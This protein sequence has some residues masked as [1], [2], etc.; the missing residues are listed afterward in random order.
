M[1]AK[2]LL[3]LGLDAALPDLIQRFA[4]EGSMPNARRLMEGGFF[5]SMITTFPP[6]TAAAW[7]AITSGR[8]TGHGGHPQPHGPRARGAPRQVAHLL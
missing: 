4:Q 5:S 8:R 6:L 1:K 2:K 3:M 7:G